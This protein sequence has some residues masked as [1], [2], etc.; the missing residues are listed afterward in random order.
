VIGE[1]VKSILFCSR[2]GEPLERK[3]GLVLGRANLAIGDGHLLRGWSKDWQLGSQTVGFVE[4]VPV[5]AGV[6]RDGWNVVEGK[7]MNPVQ[8]IIEMDV[9]GLL[10]ALESSS[11]GSCG[12]CIHFV[13]LRLVH[14]W[15]WNGWRQWRD[16]LWIVWA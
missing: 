16:V 2:F 3:L 4:I 6:V 14:A 13:R 1:I 11:N 5:C 8:I 7:T 12:R 10:E 9:V 15:A